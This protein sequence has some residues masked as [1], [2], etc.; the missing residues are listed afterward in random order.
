[1]ENI[2]KM[3]DEQ[4]GYLAE[5]ITIREREAERHRSRLEGVEKVIAELRSA[6]TRL[7]E[8]KQKL[9]EKFKI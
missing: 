5:D 8:E 9:M 6:H 7:V 2:I 4:L 3:V 1:M